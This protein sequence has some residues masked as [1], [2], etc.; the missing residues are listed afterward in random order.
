MK[1]PYFIKLCAQFMGWFQGF[2]WKVSLILFQGELQNPTCIN[3]HM[4]TC[5]IF[6]KP[7]INCL[8][9]MFYLNQS[10][11]TIKNICNIFKHIINTMWLRFYLKFCSV[12]CSVKFLYL[13]LTKI[14]FS[15]QYEFISPVSVISWEGLNESSSRAELCFFS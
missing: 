9:Y 1:R 4:N 8:N 7:K 15:L 5:V 2:I 3:V 13:I 11:K 10:I 6:N 14:C 12:G